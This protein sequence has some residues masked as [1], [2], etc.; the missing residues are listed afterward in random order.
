MKFTHGVD[1]F[2]NFCLSDIPL[3]LSSLLPQYHYSL[4]S[5]FALL[6]WLLLFASI[7]LCHTFYF[8]VSHCIPL[9]LPTCPIISLLTASLSNYSAFAFLG[10]SLSTIF[11]VT[12]SLFPCILPLV[13]SFSYYLMID[14]IGAKLHPISH[15]SYYPCSPTVLPHCLLPHCLFSD[16]G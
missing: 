6:H 5:L 15:I 4:F 12:S 8:P 14:C 2:R 13:A 16:C 1:Y 11:S 7:L 3:T 10:N 9:A